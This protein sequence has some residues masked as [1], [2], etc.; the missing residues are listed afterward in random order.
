MRQSPQDGHLPVRPRSPIIDNEA[1]RPEWGSAP[2]SEARHRLLVRLTRKYAERT[3]GMDPCEQAIGD[4]LGLSYKGSFV[5]C[6]DVGD[7]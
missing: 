6:R 2:T 5:D 1:T 7:S 4:V 3:D